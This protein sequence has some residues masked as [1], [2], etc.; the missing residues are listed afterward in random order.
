M[1][2]NHY[3]EFDKPVRWFRAVG[4]SPSNTW[5]GASRM[6]DTV[7]EPS[8]IE[9]GETLHVLVGGTFLVRADGSV[10]SGRLRLRKPAF[11]KEYGIPLTDER[12]GAMMAASGRCH[13]VE[14]PTRKIDYN[15]SREAASANRMPDGMGEVMQGKFA[16]SPLIE[17]ILRACQIADM[18]AA[19][20]AAGAKWV[21]SDVGRGSEPDSLECSV[22]I[23]FADKKRL[24]IVATPTSREIWVRDDSRE[25]APGMKAEGEEAYGL[26]PEYRNEVVTIFPDDQLYDL[27]SA[28]AEF[29]KNGRAFEPSEP[30]A[31]TVVR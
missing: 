13:E 30:A 10:E 22:R 24:S 8:R 18:G 19:V 5:F 1:R 31:A 20:A 21:Q 12:I 25:F 9:R 27:A 17:D 7:H 14:A 26:V 4:S 29:V 23:E 11:E 28:V 2:H 16:P 3:F 6:I 15:K